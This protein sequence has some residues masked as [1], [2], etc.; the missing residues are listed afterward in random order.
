M[1]GDDS[2]RRHDAGPSMLRGLLSGSISSAPGA[3]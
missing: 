1:H 2:L 3:L